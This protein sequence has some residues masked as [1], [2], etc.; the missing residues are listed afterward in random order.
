MFLML[1]LKCGFFPDKTV[2]LWKVMERTK[3]AEGYNLKDDGGVLRAP[4]S[5]NT[6]RVPVFKVSAL[7]KA[8]CL[9][10]SWY[11]AVSN[12]HL[13]ILLTTYQCSGCML[14]K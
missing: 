3:R 7:I 14:Y 4:T 5:I 6:L 8:G 12:K 10:T 9:L 11:V 2:K 1:V 13:G